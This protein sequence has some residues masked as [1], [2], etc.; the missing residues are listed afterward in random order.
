MEVWQEEEV[1]KGDFAILRS[2]QS[3]VV[4]SIASFHD[5][6]VLSNL[7]EYCASNGE[8]FMRKYSYWKLRM[9]LL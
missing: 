2:H 7:L 1:G 3:C 4:T 6:Y 5:L 9:T 8:S